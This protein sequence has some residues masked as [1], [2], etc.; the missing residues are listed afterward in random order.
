MNKIYNT[1]NLFPK[2]ELTLRKIRKETHGYSKVRQHEYAKKYANK[3]VFVALG[4][5]AAFLMVV[6]GIAPLFPLWFFPLLFLVLMWFV[7]EFWRGAYQEIIFLANY[8]LI[9][10][11]IIKIRYKKEPMERYGVYTHYIYYQYEYKGQTFVG[12]S[13]VHYTDKES[14]YSRM[15]I[16]REVKIAF[17]P[18]DMHRLFVLDNPDYTGNVLQ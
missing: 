8:T 17:L 11:K 12:K 13:I 4:E 3:R 16:G 9:S 7:V 18:P 10:G 5:A 15:P 1:F 14:V 2:S 6:L